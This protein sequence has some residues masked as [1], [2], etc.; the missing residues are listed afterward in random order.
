MI[1]HSK[2]IEIASHNNVFRFRKE[3]LTI[4][5]FQSPKIISNAS[6]PHYN[7]LTFKTVLKVICSL[8]WV[9]CRIET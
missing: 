5:I 6:A 3:M 8:Y 1:L 2:F 7:T 9:A 4:L